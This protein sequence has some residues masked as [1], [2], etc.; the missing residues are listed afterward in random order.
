MLVFPFVGCVLNCRF[1][2]WF[3]EYPLNPEISVG[4]VLTFLVLS[5]ASGSV[6]YP[7]R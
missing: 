2:E 4:W 1:V 6:Y 7:F 3:D 5:N